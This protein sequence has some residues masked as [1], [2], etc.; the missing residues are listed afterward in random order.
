MPRAR[1]EAIPALF[2]ATASLSSE[3]TPF[4]GEPDSLETYLGRNYTRLDNPFRLSDHV[5]D[6]LIYIG[7]QLSVRIENRNFGREAGSGE[8]SR[9]IE[10][11][12][13]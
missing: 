10:L 2:S 9:K 4:R 12:D 7:G 8:I 11:G 1:V 13:S 6:L 5:F 3:V